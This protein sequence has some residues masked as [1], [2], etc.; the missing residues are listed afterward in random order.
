MK[1]FVL[2]WKSFAQSARAM[3]SERWCLFNMI[4]SQSLFKDYRKWKTLWNT[5]GEDIISKRNA[6]ISL[7]MWYPIVKRSLFHLIRHLKNTFSIHSREIEFYSWLKFP[8][9]IVTIMYKVKS[10]VK[11]VAY[12]AVLF[13]IAVQMINANLGLM[14][15]SVKANNAKKLAT[16]VCT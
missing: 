1:A 2:I 11:Y 10:V 4:A 13:I 3:S 16:V 7:I 6:E 8:Q 5:H 15:P 14:E 12:L 9:L